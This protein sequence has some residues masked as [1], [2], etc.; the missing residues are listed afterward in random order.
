MLNVAFA[1]CK[2]S[3]HWLSAILTVHRREF[4]EEFAPIGSK[5]IEGDPK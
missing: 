5:G 1:A 2:K 3:T 4:G